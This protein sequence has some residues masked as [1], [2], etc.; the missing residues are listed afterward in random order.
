MP[1]P[2]TFLIRIRLGV[3]V[4]ELIWAS[5]IFL[6]LDICFLLPDYSVFKPLFLQIIFLTF[7]SSFWDLGNENVTSFD[8]VPEVP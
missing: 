6:D 7:L 8:V 1:L 2:F 5:L 4:F 3:F